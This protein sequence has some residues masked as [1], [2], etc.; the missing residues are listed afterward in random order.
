MRGTLL[1][2]LTVIVGS[3]L[4]LLF[5]SA[6]QPEWETAAITGIGLVVACLGVKMFLA[7][8]Q[9]L[10]VVGAIAV[11]GVLGSALGIDHGLANLAIWAETVLGGEG[12]F[13]E[14]LLTASILFCVGPMTLLGCIQDGI[15]RKIDLLA[16]KS[17]LDGI[18]AVFLAAVFGVGVLV[19]ALV[20]L[21]I[22]GALTLAAKPLSPLT[23][24][25]AILAELTAIGGIMMV[26]IGLNLT[27][28]LDFR[29]ELFLPALVLGPLVVSFLD[30]RPPSPPEVPQVP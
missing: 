16:V 7:S 17:L 8:E 4:G 9:I 11:G 18:A 29:T 12:K 5:Q 21:V 22:Q 26:S 25:P 28:V 14:G 15:E 30:R 23:K 3:L 24:R 19:S 13:N 10:V 1:N 2:T 20:V 27:G 6:L